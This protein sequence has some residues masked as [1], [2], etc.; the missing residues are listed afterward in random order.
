MDPA[1]ATGIVVVVI[2]VVVAIVLGL[3]DRAQPDHVFLARTAT[4]YAYLRDSYRGEHEFR[5]VSQEGFPQIDQ[6]G[7]EACHAFL[8]AHG[9]RR[10]GSLEDLTNSRVYPENRTFANVYASD[11]RSM[12]AG[13]WRLQHWQNLEFGTIVRDGRFL[14]TSNA[15]PDK[16]TPPPTVDKCV[17]PNE[18]PA[19]EVLSRHRERVAA[20]EQRE[21][22]AEI[23]PIQTIEDVIAAERRSSQACGEFRRSIG[24][25][26]LEEM[27]A[28]A[29]DPAQRR[30]ARRIWQEV[31]RLWLQ[32]R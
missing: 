19:S 18:T 7:Y 32:D 14:V 9:F 1:A 17:L 27:V 26:T 11:D 12:T 15:A 30:A 3:R 22:A 23:Q 24:L 29:E 28:L 5:W 8:C 21:P 25:I 2:A 4:L 6:S 16:M 31:Q 13:T 20:F 10:L